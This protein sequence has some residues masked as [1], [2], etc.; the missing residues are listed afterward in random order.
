[1]V[2]MQC[3]LLMSRALGSERGKVIRS[4]TYELVLTS[5]T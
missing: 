4:G 2:D 1:M 5:P 3:S